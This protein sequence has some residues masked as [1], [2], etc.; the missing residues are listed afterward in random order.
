MY[1]VNQKVSCHSSVLCTKI[2][3]TAL[4]PPKHII[5]VFGSKVSSN[6]TTASGDTFLL[7][8]EWM[9]SC[10]ENHPGCRNAPRGVLELPTRLVNV[11][12]SDGSQTP[13]LVIPS[14]GDRAVEY[15]TLS[16]CWGGADIYKLTSD[17]FSTLLSGLSLETLSKTFKDAIIIT[18]CLGFRYIWIDSLCIFRTLHPI[19]IMKRH[20]WVVY[21]ETALAQLLHSNQW[22]GMVVVLLN[23][24]RAYTSR[25][26][27]S[28]TGTTLHCLVPKNRSVPCGVHL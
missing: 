9:R 25:A 10:R 20:V 4:D 16:H 22:T 23:A 27:F 3:D 6:H 8:L 7:A 11:G 28:M 24:A 26:G 14:R 13:K 17:T 19:G 21:T 2:E 15:L 1:A 5:Q 18:R 12:P